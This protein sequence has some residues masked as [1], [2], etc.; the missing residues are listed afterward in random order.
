M[1]F[2]VSPLVR[3]G[4]LGVVKLVCWSLIAGGGSLGPKAEI[5]YRLHGTINA[6]GQ[7]IA[8]DRDG[9]ISVSTTEWG[10]VERPNYCNV[11]YM[12]AGSNPVNLSGEVPATIAQHPEDVQLLFA[13]NAESKAVGLNVTAAPKTVMDELIGYGIRGIFWANQKAAGWATGKLI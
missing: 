10:K 2:D 8:V 6:Q 12:L 4:K 1:P 5:Y 13:V 3:D 11:T 7:S 9:F